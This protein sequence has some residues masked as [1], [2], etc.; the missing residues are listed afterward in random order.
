VTR[1]DR[2]YGSAHE[3]KLREERIKDR[4]ND[5]KFTGGFR[6]IYRSLYTIERRPLG[7]LNESENISRHKG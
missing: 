2:S 1:G 3:L 7:K 4:L 5:S 6:T